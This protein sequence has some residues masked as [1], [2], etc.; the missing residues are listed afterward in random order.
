MYLVVHVLAMYIMGIDSYRL[1]ISLNRYSYVLKLM[2]CILILKLVLPYD[3]HVVS[4]LFEFSFSLF[5][6]PK[7]FI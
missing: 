6:L 7:V 4:E 5:G 1:A 2:Q 3:N